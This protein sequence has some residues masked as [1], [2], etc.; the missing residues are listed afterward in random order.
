MFE[1]NNEIKVIDRYI[2]SNKWLH[3]IFFSFF[4]FKFDQIF[5]N[6]Y[7]IKVYW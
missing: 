6:N 1:N 4:F 2:T 5:E 3:V 7:E